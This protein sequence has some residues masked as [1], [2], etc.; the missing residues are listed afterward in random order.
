MSRLAKKPVVL[1]SSTQ[2]SVADGVLSVKGPKGT[3]TRPVHSFVSIEVTPEGVQV[4]PRNNS[5]LSKALT[6]TFVAHVRNMAAGVVTPFRK[7]LI[8]EGVGYKVELAG[9]ELVLSVG[10]SHKVKLPVPEGITATIEKN[11]I[12]FD[13]PDKDALGQFAAVVR[14]VKPPEPYLG[15]GFRY[16]D[17][18][19]LRKQG[20]K[21]V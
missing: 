20:K 15:K 9:K 11:T 8:L 19:I 3:L 6:G 2:V 16:S 1:A 5:K 21:A 17:E 13:S 14:A 12:H 4:S 7:S 10:F 18:K